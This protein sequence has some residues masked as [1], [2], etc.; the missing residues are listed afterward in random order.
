MHHLTWPFRDDDLWF[1][2]VL[3]VRV[4]E[5]AAVQSQVPQGF[6]LFSP[7]GSMNRRRCNPRF[8]RVF[9]TVRRAMTAPSIRSS[10]VIREG[11]PFPGPSHR[12]ELGHKLC[13]CG[14]RLMVRRAGSVL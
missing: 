3:A 1:S 4:D 11:R 2:V 5:P 10:N 7:F 6:R 8:R 9:V 13:R 12:F 14:G